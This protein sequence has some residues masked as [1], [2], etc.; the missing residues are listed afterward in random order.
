MLDLKWFEN[1]STHKVLTCFVYVLVIW[2]DCGWS[3]GEAANFHFT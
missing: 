1:Q 3:L 2:S